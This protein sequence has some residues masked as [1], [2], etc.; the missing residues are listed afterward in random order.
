MSETDVSAA[1]ARKRS[2]FVRRR[3]VWMAALL[4][5]GLA[6]AGAL[7]L[8]AFRWARPGTLPHLWVGGVPVGAMDESE[9]RTAIEDLAAR[10][11]HSTLTVHRPATAAA[12]TASLVVSAGEVGYRVDV[13]AT[14][15]LVLDRGRQPN[16]IAALADHFL[17]SFGRITLSPVERFEEELFDEW[18]ADAV[19]TL[20]TPPRE[21]E[22]VFTG[23][24]VRAVYP[25]EGAQV[26]LGDLRESVLAA[27][28]DGRSE[29]LTVNVQTLPP[30]TSD[31]A[32]EEVLSEARLALS[33]PVVLT[34]GDGALTF[35]PKVLGSLLETRLVM[36]ED[37]ASLDLVIDPD[38]LAETIGA[39][40]I[41]KV[42]SDPVNARFRLENGAVHVVPAKRGFRFDAD[43]AAVQ[44]L[45]VATSS[46]RQAR[47][48]GR[49]V[50]PGFTTAE[51]RGLGIDE[52]VSTFTTYHLCCEPR[53]TNIHRIA[54]IVDGTVVQ[55][56]ETFSLNQAAGQ[57]T[58]ENGFVPA[59]A[60]RNG[61][62]VEEVGG[63]I[64]QF[65]TTTFNAI[66][67][68]GYD[69]LEYKAHSYYFSR[70]PLGREATVSWPSPDLA[71]LNDSD[72][73]IYVDTSYDAT[74][75]TVTFYGHRDVQVE[76]ETGSPFNF[77]E[78]ETM[79]EEKPGLPKGEVNTIQEGTQGYDVI[80][81]RIFRHPD[82]HAESEEFF[83]RYKAQ[84][85]IV[86]RRSCG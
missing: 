69:F 49:E 68:G 34:R 35:E 42:E 15:D 14:L 1:R 64:S 50:I 8:G 59:P 67:F 11:E 57:R 75:I 77:T 20:S 31:A 61:E 22:L 27:I 39:D 37:I 72:A 5:L 56:G 25:A 9:L 6:V 45:N 12:G 19:R 43:R 53:V 44:L 47:L 23:A 82:G 4:V 29:P 21:G 71:F 80:V 17:T 28:R 76:S 84:P 83:T 24:R 62:F 79:C 70:Y 65:A 86:E 32:V 60:I 10:R 13:G 18:S 41:S 7:A 55:P 58:E 30:R 46:S 16:P 3:D 63:G 74:S 85:I 52:R 81:N 26:L 66:F 33:G 2:G 54:D 40:G 73:G 51:A 78:P 48:A 38:R 36:A